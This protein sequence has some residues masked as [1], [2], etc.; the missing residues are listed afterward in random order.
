MSRY[1]V[2]GGTGFI[3]SHVLRA[4]TRRGGIL[5]VVVRARSRER[6]VRLARDCGAEERI[7]PLVGDVTLPDL[8]LSR[9]DV[10][11]L[12]GH[13]DHVVHA[14]AA[15]DWSADEEAAEAVDV[16]GTRHAIELARSLDVR[17]CFHHVSSILVAGRYAGRFEERMLDEGQTFL[18]PPGECRLRA[19]LLVRE[20]REL[21]FRVYRAGILVGDS[22]T[23]AADA[24]GGP[25]HFFR[26]LR[27][28]RDLLPHWVPLVGPEGGLLQIVPV[29]YVAAAIDYLAHA[30]GLDGKT[31][32]L[33]DPAAHSAGEA[34]NILSEAARAPGFALRLGFPDLG[35]IV[36]A[37][38]G[39]RLA[40]GAELLTEGMLGELGIPPSVSSLIDSPTTFDAG[41][42]DA[43]LAG[44]GICCPPLESYAERIWSYWEKDLD[45]ERAVSRPP[46]GRLDGKVIVV[47]GAS[48]GIGRE[49]A[50]QVAALGARALLLARR[51]DV[52]A[53]V[54]DEIRASGGDAWHY[55]VDLTDFDACDRA[56]E[57]IFAD[58]EAVDVLI[59]NAGHSIRRSVEL[60]LHRFHDFQRTMQLNY[61]AAVRLI[62]A[63]LPGMRARRH[64]HVVNVSTAGVQFGAPRF[65]AYVA[66]K[67]ALDAFSRSLATEVMADGIHV[68]TVYMGLV[69]T[70]MIEPTRV[71][72]NL[73]AMSPEH[74]AAQ[75]VDA[76]FSQPATVS[77][78]FGTLAVILHVLAPEVSD[79]VLSMLY[80][81][82]PEGRGSPARAKS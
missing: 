44:S 71:Y 64:G 4:L 68:T 9:E 36:P 82:S 50:R 33:L 59:N 30:P 34:F 60:S 52:L 67:A 24:A 2:T 21:P 31:F 46:K 65:A 42:A 15:C 26:L 79:R 69:R 81:I 29:D 3:G 10:S 14:A 70:P 16:E 39:D 18:H 49:V 56:V 25:Y 62:L 47:T 41:E 80:R 54:A 45:P 63:F 8:G 66:S 1:L 72:R 28:L 5:H 75:V 43:A 77:S 11:A 74:A 73:P 23:G 27:G 48:S 38:L 78:A 53:E 19:E 55:P 22:Q 20:L 61:F 13:V 40:D 37:F 35:S 58:H 51:D 7:H 32:H 12:R 17:S 6:L 57:R 76:L